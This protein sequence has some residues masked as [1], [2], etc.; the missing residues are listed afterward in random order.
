MKVT[1]L[2]GT[3]EAEPDVLNYIAVAFHVGAISDSMQG[4]EGCAFL[5]KEASETIMD[6]LVNIG[7]YD[8]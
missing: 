4:L 6:A 5:Q 7:Y 3:I 8:E 1:T 2:L